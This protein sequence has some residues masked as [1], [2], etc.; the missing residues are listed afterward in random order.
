MAETA[1]ISPDY[2]IVIPERIREKYN[3]RPDQEIVFI[4]KDN[5]IYIVPDIPIQQLRGYLKGMDTSNIRE[6]TDREL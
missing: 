3:L 5:V 2:H 1:I 4:E 6:K